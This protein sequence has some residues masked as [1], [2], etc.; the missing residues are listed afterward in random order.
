M[1]FSVRILMFLSLMTDT[2]NAPVIFTQNGAPRRALVSLSLTSRV[3][4]VFNPCFW[5]IGS[6][7]FGTLTC[8]KISV[9]LSHEA[10]LIFAG[11]AEA[12]SAP[13]R[14]CNF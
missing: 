10:Q 9:Q 14:S 8:G 3:S 12:R 11:S 13:A 5:I 1:Y 6:D 2:Y 4:E 7:S